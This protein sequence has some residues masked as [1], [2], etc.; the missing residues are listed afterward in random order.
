MTSGYIL[1]SGPPHTLGHCPL[2]GALTP[3]HD[4]VQYC[5]LY[6]ELEIVKYLEDKESGSDL[7]EWLVRLTAHV[8]VATVLGSIKASSDTVE[9]EGRRI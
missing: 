5:V 3:S 1:P 6:L 8:E 9:C 2:R 7:A 4:T